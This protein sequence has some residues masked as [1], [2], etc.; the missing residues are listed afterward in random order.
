MKH[1]HYYRYCQTCGWAIKTKD[2]KTS[3]ACANECGA[4]GN[5]GLNF[6]G[7]TNDEHRLFIGT[8][9]TLKQRLEELRVNGEQDGQEH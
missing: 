6:V 2:G 1:I 9:G 7:M 4:C 5:K 3:L 8:T